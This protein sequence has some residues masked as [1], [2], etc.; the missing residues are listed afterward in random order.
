MKPILRPLLASLAA[1]FGI[2]LVGV[3]LLLAAA[4]LLGAPTDNRASMLV[5]FAVVS[6]LALLA[7]VPLIRFAGRILRYSRVLHIGLGMCLAL[8][9]AFLGWLH[10]AGFFDRSQVTLSNGVLLIQGNLDMEL[11]AQFRRVLES[12]D[13][14]DVRVRLRSPGGQIHVAMAIGREIHRR[15]LDVE[16]D[17]LCHSSCANYLFTAGRNK[18]L[19]SADQVR[20]HGGALQPDFVAAALQLVEQGRQMLDGED[21]PPDMDMELFRELCGLA[22]GLPINAATNILAEKA[23]FEEIGVSAL[24]PVYGQYGEYSGWFDDGVHDNFSYLSEDYALLGVGNVMV[25][26]PEAGDRLD[27]RVFRARTSASTIDALQQEIN[28]I[29]RRIETAAPFGTGEIWRSLDSL[30]SD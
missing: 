21:I 10:H 12:S 6:V 1:I 23:F 26:E 4:T 22:A 28:A 25:S 19:Q 15:R 27:G 2:A 29:Y 13:V 7:G 30:P 3:V 5:A 9:L 17:R 8:C 16:V 18:Y 24:T 11:L 14:R 20:F